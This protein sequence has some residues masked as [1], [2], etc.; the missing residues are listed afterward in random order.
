LRCRWPK[1]RFGRVLIPRGAPGSLREAAGSCCLAER[2][3]IALAISSPSSRSLRMPGLLTPR[4]RARFSRSSRAWLL[5]GPAGVAPGNSQA[6]LQINQ[7]LKI[8]ELP[9]ADLS[10]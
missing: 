2:F 6:P 7:L 10:G 1:S 5:G 9:G 3:A 4:L 8:V